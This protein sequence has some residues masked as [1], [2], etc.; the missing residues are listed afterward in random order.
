MLNYQAS[1]ALAVSMASLAGHGQPA[2]GYFIFCRSLSS[3]SQ[4]PQRGKIQYKALQN[5]RL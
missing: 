1:Y 5:A 4:S 2:L 3:P